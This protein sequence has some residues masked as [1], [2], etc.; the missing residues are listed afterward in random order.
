MTHVEIAMNRIITLI[1][2]AAMSAGSIDTKAQEL[3]RRIEKLVSSDAASQAA[4][5]ICA[6]KGDGQKL[7]DINSSMML[8][9][10]SNMKLISTGAAVH[11]LGPEFRFETSIGHDG[12]ITE[13]VLNGNVYIIGGGD[14]TLGSTD[15]IATPIEK[16]FSQWHA[17]LKNAGISQINGRIIGDGSL[18]DQTMEHPTWL[19]EDIGTYYG[20]GTTGLMFYEN[21]QSFRVSAG[22]YVGDSVNITPSYPQTPWMEFRYSCTTGENGTGDKLFLY[23]S[24][25]AP[26]AEVRGTFGLDRTAKRLDCSNKFPEYTC[27]YYFKEYLNQNGIACDSIGDFKLDKEWIRRGEIKELGKTYSPQLRRIIFETNHIS[28]NVFA[29]T[30]LRSLGREM[31]GDACYESSCIAIANILTGLGIDTSRGARIKDGS[32]L[33]RQ[34]Y[35]SSDFFCRFLLG[36]MESPHFEHFVNSLPSPGSDGSMIYNM[37]KYSDSIKSRIKVKSGSMN[38]VRCYSGYVIPTDGGKEDVIIF[39]LMINNCTSSSGQMRNLMDSIMAEL[40]KEN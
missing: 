19:M 25:L 2:L 24:D 21:M 14:P 26:V 3:Q 39:S 9:P 1:C 31:T 4:V 34:N 10:A 17:M 37:R 28:N 13:G 20:A 5:S 30:L 11:H 38:G 6:I 15:S 40:A 35:I 8:V 32:G 18:F 22:A 33:S 27:A 23:T 36:M 16:V 7:V 29:E 12:E